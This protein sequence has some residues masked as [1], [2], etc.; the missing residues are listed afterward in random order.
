MT[1]AKKTGNDP[2]KRK[3]E[4]RASVSNGEC[5]LGAGGE[6]HQVAGGNHPVLTT[7]QGTP[8]SDHQNSLRANPGGPTLLEDFALREKITH[9]D[10]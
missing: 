10:H 2:G 6:P 4:K 1:K 9:F 3:A 7:N 5:R 8:I